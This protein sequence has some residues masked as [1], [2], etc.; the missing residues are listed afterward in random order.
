M[1]SSKTYLVGALVFIAS[2]GFAAGFTDTFDSIDPAWTTDRTEPAGFT[3]SFFDGDNRLKIDVNHSSPFDPG[4]PNTFYNTEGRSRAASLTQDWE[5]AGDV[6]ISADMLDGA[7]LRR[8]DLWARDAAP[9]ASAYYPIIGVV[10]N[11]ASDPFNYGGN[12]TTR[13]RVW[14]SDL[15]VW[16]NLSNTVTAGW[17]RLSITSHGGNQLSYAIDSVNVFNQTMAGPV[18]TDLSRVFVQ[19]YNFGGQDYSVYWDNVSA[20][21]V[22]EPASMTA[23]GLGAIALIRKRRKSAK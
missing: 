18:N 16:D 20:Q 17:H 1:K 13:Y 9:E 19:S 14:D 5:V 12:L 6:Y 23:L 7:N 11:D 22:P 8:T 21:A 15:G 2:Q 3:S 4:G 10:R